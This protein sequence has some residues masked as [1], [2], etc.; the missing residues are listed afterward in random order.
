MTF[1][2]NLSIL[3]INNFR[4]VSLSALSFFICLC[5]L[6]SQTYNPETGNTH[7]PNGTIYISTS[8]HTGGP[9]V[10]GPDREDGSWERVECDKN[11]A[12]EKRCAEILEEATPDNAETTQSSG[13]GVGGNAYNDVLGAVVVAEAIEYRSKQLKIRH[14]VWAKQNGKWIYATNP[15]E[16][17][18]KIIATWKKKK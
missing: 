4:S 5:S 6:S 16:W 7:Y 17:T 3:K 10:T 14:G 11:Q 1:L 9:V 13:N 18:K 15:R 12:S 8:E 2:F